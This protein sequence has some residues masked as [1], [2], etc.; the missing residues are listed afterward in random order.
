MPG[1]RLVAS[2]RMPFTEMGNPIISAYKLPISQSPGR[3]QQRKVSSGTKRQENHKAGG[4][5]L[6]PPY[7]HYLKSQDNKSTQRARG[8]SGGKKGMGQE[9]TI[10]VGKQGWG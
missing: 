8:D 4:L 1:S 9:K 10:Q 6:W 2:G 5:L 7:D 3:K